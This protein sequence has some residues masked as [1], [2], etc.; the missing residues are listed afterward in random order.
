MADQPEPVADVGLSERHG[1]WR[2][3]F[4]I[5]PDR[6]SRRQFRRV[7]AGWFAVMAL[8]VS[9][10]LIVRLIEGPKPY[11]ASTAFAL[12][13][14][15][16]PILFVW[17]CSLLI[18]VIKRLRDI[19]SP[20]TACRSRAHQGERPDLR[21][22]SVQ[23]IGRGVAFVVVIIAVPSLYFAS[24]AAVAQMLRSFGPGVS[25]PVLDAVFWTPLALLVAWLF[26]APSYKEQRS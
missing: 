11:T 7:L 9:P 10:P 25:A 22:D 20:P 13:V 4:G 23:R 21:G 2:T 12:R 3:Y 5:S 8:I 16:M 26:L 19:C 24:I 17:L 14:W 15:A 18:V 1:F 6:L